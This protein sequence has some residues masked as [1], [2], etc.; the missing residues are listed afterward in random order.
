MSTFRRG[1]NTR[2]SLTGGE[3]ILGCARLAKPGIL[4][5]EDA[6]ASARREA[7]ELRPRTSSYRAEAAESAARYELRSSELAAERNRNRTLEVRRAHDVLI[8]RKQT[9]ATKT[10]NVFFFRKNGNSIFFRK[11]K[12]KIIR[13]ISRQDSHISGIRAHG[14]IHPGTKYYKIG[15]RKYA[16]AC[17]SPPDSDLS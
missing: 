4:A 9:S 11:T 3:S 16:Y 12:Y 13:R 8:F 1:A 10:E 17:S 7:E 2:T 6:L 5:L 15:L 14:H